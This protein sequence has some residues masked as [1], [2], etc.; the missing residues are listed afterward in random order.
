MVK[1]KN[2]WSTLPLTPTTM[3]INEPGDLVLGV[4]H[5]LPD[6]GHLLALQPH[7]LLVDGRL[8]LHRHLPERLPPAGE[9]MN[10]K[11]GLG[12]HFHWMF[13][14]MPNSKLRNWENLAELPK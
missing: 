9:R 2:C 14:Q 3:H 6:G 1:T 10:V 11:S 8:P 13:A 5:P 12:L 7:Q 4:G